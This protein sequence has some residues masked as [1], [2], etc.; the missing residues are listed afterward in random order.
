MKVLAIDNLTED[1]IV[2]DNVYSKSGQLIVRRHSILTKQMILRLKYYEI[3]SITIETGTYSDEVQQSIEHKKEVERSHSSRI[4]TSDDFLKF[5]EN[6]LTMVNRLADS[7]NDIIYKNI[8]I[9]KESLLTDTILFFEDCPS[10]YSIFGMLHAMKQ[11][12]NSTFAHS[13][14]V[15]IISR[16]MGSWLGMPQEDLDNLSLAGILHDI[17]KCQIPTDILTK[18]SKLSPAEFELMK[19]HPQ[20]GYDQLKSQNLDERVKRVALLHHERYDKTGYP[21]GIT[22]GPE[23]IYASIVSIADVYDALTSDRCYRDALCPFD[24]IAT[25]EQEGLQKYHPLY[26]LTFLQKIANSYLNCEVLLS[27]NSIARTVFINQQLT[28]PI[29]Q[30]NDQTFINLEEHPDLYIQAIV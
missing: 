30:L 12:D 6:Y 29:V 14:N 11:I 8:A 1:M 27:D 28:R 26:I 19:M 18:P 17:G 20:F 21:F 23:D 16:L 3:S 22:P 15:S 13:L 24:V 2:A 7:L 25:F 10:T 4:V 5:K 9:D